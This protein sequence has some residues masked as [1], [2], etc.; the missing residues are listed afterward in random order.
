MTTHY[1]LW[2]MALTCLVLACD[3]SATNDPAD[4]GRIAR[5]AQA[6]P[7]DM[8]PMPDL[9]VD[10]PDSHVDMPD[11][12]DMGGEAMADAAPEAECLRDEQC[13]P[14]RVCYRERCVDGQRC[15]DEGMCPEGLLC[16]NDL[17]LPDPTAAGGLAAEPNLLVYT[18]FEVGSTAVRNTRITNTG[19]GV[20]T[21]TELNLEGSNTFVIEDG[22]QLPLRLVPE[23]GT[24]VLIRYTADD[25][26]PDNGR[27]VVRTDRAQAEPVIVQLGTERKQVGGADPCLE[28]VPARVDF[29][30][31]VRGQIARRMVE[32]VS[33][34]QA[35][36]QINAIRRGQ[37][38][39]GTLPTTFDIV[40]PV[41]PLVLQ[42]G[43]RQMVELNYAPRRAGLEAGF[44]N[45]LSTDPQ[46]PET[47]VDVTALATPP[48]I[49][50]VA[51]HVRLSWD[52][53]LNDVDLHLL[54]PG[55]QIWTCEG[56]CYF[57]NPNPNWGDP[58]RFEDDPFLD[59]DDVDGFGPENINLEEPQ[60]GTYRVLVQY[61]AEHESFEA[62]RATVEILQ[63]G[64]V[65]ASYGPQRLNSVGDEW[66]VVDIEWPALNLVPLGQVSNNPVGNLCGG[67]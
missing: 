15:D 32:L 65:V 24:D 28:V 67:F 25:D 8:R 61:W 33:C 58:N 11:M 29:G 31:V 26:L 16:I 7:S 49:E 59:L 2:A 6:A 60:P 5:D 54:G 12:P 3:D 13:G 30:P 50:E 36:V 56:D 63:F 35:P 9:G 46:S 44:W 39:F 17:C 45:I 66:L 51:L 27:L 62:P 10:A 20:L 18:F 55:G 52:T 38:F 22:P 43:Q 53:D 1:A 40:H 47:R 14:G 37:T 19:E 21:L 4:A 64:N 48:P 34:G 42:P 41:Y 23:Q 57:S